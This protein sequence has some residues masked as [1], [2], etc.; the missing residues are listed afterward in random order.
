MNWGI[1]N[2]KANATEF[3]IASW[4]DNVCIKN[5][6]PSL[7]SQSA[8]MDLGSQTARIMNRRSLFHSLWSLQISYT[9][10]IDL[11]SRSVRE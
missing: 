4:Y 8:M 3:S 9:K 6:V 11:K 7:P 10:R 5:S 2:K 1:S